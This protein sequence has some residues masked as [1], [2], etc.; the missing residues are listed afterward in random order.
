MTGEE[1]REMRRKLGYTQRQIASELDMTVVTISSFE[2]N[3]VPIKKTV[4]LAVKAL[5]WKKKFRN[6]PFN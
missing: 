5:C 4:E 1:F 2:N 6:E 3:R